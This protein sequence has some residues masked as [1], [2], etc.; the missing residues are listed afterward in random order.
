MVCSQDYVIFVKE[1]VNLKNV[2]I[3]LSLKAVSLRS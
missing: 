1:K 2:Y 3:D